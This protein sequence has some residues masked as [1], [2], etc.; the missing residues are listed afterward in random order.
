MKF[1]IYIA[2]QFEIH[3]LNQFFFMNGVW[4]SEII[5]KIQNDIQQNPKKSNKMCGKIVEITIKEKHKK[6]T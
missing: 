2:N 6:A 5:M 3:S 1:G 4:I